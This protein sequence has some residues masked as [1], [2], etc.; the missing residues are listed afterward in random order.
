M[1]FIALLALTGSVTQGI[2]L[3]KFVDSGIPEKMRIDIP[4]EDDP[5]IE[6][7]PQKDSVADEHWGHEV[8][9]TGH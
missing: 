4:E 7:P 8:Q 5:F 2:V 3:W 6:V 9:R 1:K